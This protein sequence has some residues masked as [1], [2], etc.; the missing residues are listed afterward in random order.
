MESLKSI[1]QY[2]R[3]DIIGGKYEVYRLVG[4][5]GFGVV[6]LVYSHETQSPYALKMLDNDSLLEQQSK[7]L[8]K[9]EANALV[10]LDIHPFIIPL[11]AVDEIEDQLFILMEY[12]APNKDGLNS[13]EGY[14]DGPFVD[15]A[16]KLRWAIQICYG[17]EYVYSCGIKSHRDLKPSNILIDQ[18]GYVKIA[19]FGL[20][21]VKQKEAPM[22]QSSRKVF[23]TP[24]YMPPEQYYH[25]DDCDQQSDIYSFGV[26]LYEL[27]TG[28]L[29]PFRSI[30][31]EGKTPK[32]LTDELAQTSD[33]DFALE[34]CPILSPLIRRCISANKEDRYQTFTEL[35]AEFENVLT[36]E[37]G[38]TFDLPE[39]QRFAPSWRLNSRGASLTVLGRFQE[40]LSFF[41][42]AL[43]LENDRVKNEEDLA[44]ILSNKSNALNGLRRFDEALECTIAATTSSPSL[45]NAWYNKGISCMNLKKFAEAISCFDRFLSFDSSITAQHYAEA[46]H[47]KGRCYDDL[48]LRDEAIRCYDTAITLKDWKWMFYNDKG[49]ALTDINR[50]EDAITLFD[51]AI[52][53]WPDYKIAWQNKGTALFKL[54]QFDHALR[55][56]EKVLEIDPDYPEAWYMR[57]MCLNRHYRHEEA[58]ACLDNAIDL[59]S[60]QLKYSLKKGTTLYHLFEY[61]QAIKCFDRVIA[62][63]SSHPE[64]MLL[65]GITQLDL[66]L[67]DNSIDSLHNLL[68]VDPSCADGWYIL[69]IAQHTSLQFTESTES[70]LH[71]LASAPPRLYYLVRL[72]LTQYFSTGSFSLS[73]KNFSLFREF[74]SSNNMV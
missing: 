48:G 65:K 39:I 46:W 53:R 44:I 40:A 20:V 10:D 58:L 56:F 59:N 55:C 72:L 47:W 43:A 29:F 9:Q 41:D 27:F 13:L 26:I 34:P 60:Q 52:S 38:E 51:E 36:S 28:R 7:K 57:A 63:D 14:I 70:Y 73:E 69:A 12:I 15:L 66:G 62:N 17:M 32:Q 49:A 54:S 61:K 42:A 71:F 37:T 6:Y 35:R 16:Q 8:F 24:R 50:I 21:N 23:G 3:G 64:A 31:C 67:I 2:K 11:Y 5:G 1:F 22:F 33:Y 68:A 19:D 18:H 25:Y 74:S 30:P 4:Y 45:E